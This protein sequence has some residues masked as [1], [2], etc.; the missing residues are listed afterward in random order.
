[1]HKKE[2][3]LCLDFYDAG[4]SIGFASETRSGSALRSTFGRWD[5]SC[6]T[7]RRRAER[8]EYVRIEHRSGGAEYVRH[9]ESRAIVDRRFQVMF[10]SVAGTSYVHRVFRGTTRSCTFSDQRTGALWNLTKK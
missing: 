1:M 4:F 2:A 9:A 5:S 10:R 8:R 7:L 3:E 6:R